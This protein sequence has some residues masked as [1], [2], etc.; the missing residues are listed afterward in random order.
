MSQCP[1]R[2]EICLREEDTFLPQHFQHFIRG[3][4]G[5]R[6]IEDDNIG[7]DVF[8]FQLK[9]RISGDSLRK[10]ARLVVVFFEAIHIV[11]KC[12]ERSGCNDTG[13]PHA[14]SKD[15]AESPGALDGIF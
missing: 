14:T 15:L 10:L 11:L 13:L 1:Q 2:G 7:L 4:P 8:Y 3:L 5:L 12:V 9:G 6:N